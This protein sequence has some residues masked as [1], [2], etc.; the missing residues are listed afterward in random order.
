MCKEDTPFDLFSLLGAQADKGGTW[1]PT[2]PNGLFDPKTNLAGTYLYI[3][4]SA[5]CKIDTAKVTV[6][7]LP[8][9]IVQLGRDTTTC[10]GNTVTIKSLS[11]NANTLLQWSNGASNTPQ[12]EVTKT[13][14]YSLQNTDNNGCKGRDEIVVTFVA[15]QSIKE[16]VTI[17]DGETYTLGDM[18]YTQAGTYSH[19]FKNRFGC[20][21]LYTVNLSV[22]L[23]LKVYPPNVFS[24]NGDGHNDFFTL[25]T[26]EQAEKINILRIFDRWGN[27]VYE[28]NNFPPNDDTKGWDGTYRGI[29]YNS[30][31]VFTFFA[32]VLL[33]SGSTSFVK[34]DVMI[35]R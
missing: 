9:P 34:G 32:E 23:L 1:K 13:G 29:T 24:P 20:D 35:M 22:Q 28:R 7:I 25:F 21:S 31:E 33:K 17:K 3:V 14:T 30:G 2:L 26:N 27:L 10:E 19:T 4:G 5:G 16:N 11:N 6:S 15:P 12:I 18:I 8:N